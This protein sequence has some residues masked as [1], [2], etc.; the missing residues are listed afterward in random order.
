MNDSEH[1][2][3][4]GVKTIVRAVLLLWLVLAFF[5]GDNGAFVGAPEALPLPILAGVLTPI[6][7]FLVAFWTVG[8]FRDFVMSIDL[9]VMAGI[10][11][12]RFGGLGFIAL[13]AYGVLPGIF[14]GQPDLVT[15]QSVLLL[16]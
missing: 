13:Y 12:W 16:L 6:L 14:A 5:L 9:P 15:W 10:Q 4:K 2:T 1:I 3:D 8:P 7:V 11:A